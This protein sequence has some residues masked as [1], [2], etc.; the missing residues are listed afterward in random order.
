MHMRAPHIRRG[1]QIRTRGASQCPSLGA[2]RAA[3]GRPGERAGACGHAA[4]LRQEGGGGVV[5]QRRDGA[6]AGQPQ[7]GHLPP[8]G[9]AQPLSLAQL[10]PR[11]A[12]G[13]RCHVAELARGGGSPGSQLGLLSR[14][15]L[16]ASTRG[17]LIP[18]LTDCTRLSRAAHIWHTH[19][20][21]LSKGNRVGSVR[22]CT[23]R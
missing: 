2:A 10:H 4:H 17:L 15:R 9:S 18:S 13:P 8:R 1:R 21:T 5:V 19:V 22:P 7:A 20:G 12:A 14:P 16:H 6:L 3:G 23:T 11:C